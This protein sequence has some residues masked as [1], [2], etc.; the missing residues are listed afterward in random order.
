MTS[1]P[2][3][4]SRLQL[5]ARGAS[6]PAARWP[7]A[8][9][10]GPPARLGA[11]RAPLSPSEPKW[12]RASPHKVSIIAR[13]GRARAI[14]LGWARPPEAARP[15]RP[16]APLAQQG[17]G[18]RRAAPSGRIGGRVQELAREQ[19]LGPAESIS[20][21]APDR[22]RGR[23]ITTA[24]RP[25][26]ARDLG[27]VG[28]YRK[29][30]CTTRPIG[31]R[32]PIGRAGARAGGGGRRAGGAPLSLAGCA[33][34]ALGARANGSAAPALIVLRRLH[35]APADPAAHLAPDDGP[36]VGPPDGSDG[37]D[38]GPISARSSRSAPPAPPAPR[39][40]GPTANRAQFKSD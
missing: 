40:R 35:N 30:C 3:C 13:L 25:L 14:L 5:W 19:D 24:R 27:P 12:T 28:N 26:A 15:S 8:Y 4:R 38:I 16:G 2:R 32:R 36:A 37:P 34:G 20:G 39:P 18:G 31:R 23:Q 33:V 10:R 17:P 7:A 1:E 11:P 29:S 9:R 22:H 21:P 6:R